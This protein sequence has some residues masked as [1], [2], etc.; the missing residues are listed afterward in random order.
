M[1][2]DY[3]CRPSQL[4]KGDPFDLSL[5]LIVSRVGWEF[6]YEQYQQAKNKSSTQAKGA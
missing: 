1:S 6:D 5:D 2:K 4:L 3:S